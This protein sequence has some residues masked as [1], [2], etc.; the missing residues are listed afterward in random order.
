MQYLAALLYAF[1]LHSINVLHSNII[2]FIK[3]SVADSFEVDDEDD[4]DN[5]GTFQ[6]RF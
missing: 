4:V 6:K 5:D 1:N 2:D 3:V